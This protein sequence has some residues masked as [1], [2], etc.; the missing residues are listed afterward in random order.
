MIISNKNLSLHLLDLFFADSIH[1]IRGRYV[2]FAKCLLPFNL[3]NFVRNPVLAQYRPHPR[4]IG[5]CDENL[6][7]VLL[8]DHA[9]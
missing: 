2:A 1:C 5:V 3:K 6:S 8:A 7:E 4:L 9:Q